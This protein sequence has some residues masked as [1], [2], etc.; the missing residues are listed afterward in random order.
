MEM[1]LP[2]HS[3]DFGYLQDMTTMVIKATR[4][5]PL[6]EKIRVTLNLKRP[7]M[8]IR[9]P[10][11]I[12][13]KGKITERD[14]RF[15]VALD[16]QFSLSE[17][18]EDGV[19]ALVLHV[20]NPPWYSRQLKEAMQMS[21]DPKSF[22]WSA[23][24]TWSRQ[25]DI[26]EEKETYQ[27]ID[28]SPVSVRKLQ[29]S[30]NIAHW[31]TFRLTVKTN[32]ER[33]DDLLKQ[34]LTALADFNIRVTRNPNPP[35]TIVR[36]TAYEATIWNL[37]NASS[38]SSLSEQLS[39]PYLDFG[40]R[41]QLEVC[42][43]H[44]WLNEYALDSSFLQRLAELP[45]QRAKQMLVHID[46][47]EQWVYDPQSIFTDMRYTKPVRAG[48]LPAN[49]AEIYNATV[50][51]TGIL[52][53][54]PSVEIS[55]RI[56]R[57]YQSH[58]D[59]FLRVRFEDDNYRGKTR[60]F[61]ATNGSMKL[62]FERVRR[63]LKEGITIGD[64]HYDFLA[65]GN[66]QLR[67]HGVWFFASSHSPALTADDIRRDMGTFDRENVVA[68]RAARMGQCF[69]T[70]VPVPVLGRK[71]W[72][73]DQIR[74][75]KTANGQY[76]FTD[77]VGKI[78]T[79]AARLVQINL[80]TGG[81]DPPSALQFRLGGCKG[82]LTLDL[83]LKNVSVQIRDSQFKFDCE[84]D[85]LEII[86][87]SEFWQ[88][89]LNRQL[90]LVLSANGVPDSVFLQKQEL[91]I[92]ALDAAL[93]DESAALKALRFTVDPNQITLNIAAMIEAG[94]SHKTDP[95]VTSLIR[96]WRAW[97][98]KYLKE[99]AKIPVQH[100]AFVLG[101]ADE[102]R[103]LKGH[104]DALQPGP[105][106]TPREMENSLP[107]IFIQYSDPQEKGARRVYEG[108]CVVARNPSLHRGD[109]RVVKA[110]DIPE[111][112]H[113]CD[114]VVMPTTGDRDLP[115]MCSG[116][117]LD[118]DDYIVIWDPELIPQHW[119]AE[120]FHYN[121][122]EPL[123][124]DEI[125]TNDIINFFCDYMQNDFLGRIAVAHLA[126]ADFLDD[127]LDSD[128]CLKLVELHSMAVDYPKTGVPAEMSR[129]LERVHWP[130]FME[131]KKAGFYHS[132]KVLGRLYDAVERVNFQPHWQG[133][134]DPRILLHK[135][136]E[137][138]MQT[139]KSLKKSY[140]ES[141]RRIMA[142]HQI[143]SEFEVWSTFVLDH[144]K[145]ARDYKFHEEIGQHAR[146]LKEQFHDA[147]CQEAGGHV[148]E[149]LTPFAITAY[150]VTH[151]EFQEALDM[152]KATKGEHLLVDVEEEEGDDKS[153]EVEMPF[154]SFPWVL[155]DTLQKIA[156]NTVIPETN[157]KVSGLDDQAKRMKTELDAVPSLRGWSTNG[158][159]LPDPYVPIERTAPAQPEMVAAPPPPIPVSL[160]DL[161]PIQSPSKAQSTVGVEKSPSD[162]SVSSNVSL[163]VSPTKSTSSKSDASENQ[164]ST[165]SRQPF[166]L[167]PSLSGA[168]AD[169]LDLDQLLIFTKPTNTPLI[170][171]EKSVSQPFKDPALM[172]SAEIHALTGGAE[173]EDDDFTF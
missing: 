5:D 36:D 47:H 104:F 129:D 39:A 96:L 125:S 83:N 158:E 75:I 127:G 76:T 124:K 40:L 119:N 93:E 111:L 102:T 69:S 15:F 73:R 153:A 113:L 35:F 101:V 46:I 22:R 136:E 123:R 33:P 164:S 144:S 23:D 68:K 42:I 4:T 61:P 169:L 28:S 105:G 86:R 110:V 147:F 55:N 82:V 149:K 97:T 24:D 58:S 128:P 163:A 70:T 130:H 65:W 98:L 13:S 50:T 88:P 56:V 21:H 137:N 106:A 89:Y 118:G 30:I 120:P 9:F 2:A 142:Q 157:T 121:A 51:A 156:R 27:K 138:L 10:V 133:S 19:S 81:T 52:F 134:F 26:V 57:K 38:A 117:D 78:S 6:A 67:E 99:K 16:D 63:T 165:L 159:H 143:R 91:C 79:L 25:T 90:I 95:F 135:P 74:D 34:F 112:H 3:I 114:V 8:E 152:K 139:V 167:K 80:K 53:H 62:I 162:S 54:T 49:C 109:V 1:A 150:H 161:A 151:N 171:A 41:Y 155:Q 170:E 71:S 160:N 100:G 7:E 59:R 43:S 126:A 32:P 154:I 20:K 48:P 132:R 172:T 11:S 29:N 108:I 116:G 45:P 94:F 31:T 145:A 148:F 17:V 84:S 14:Y 64:R 37:L 122:P 60:L 131:K 166:V 146:T 168:G 103:R 115:S 12:K 85:E 87:V 107:Q 77:G 72:R 18:P 92:Q 66:S 173:D 140:D 44:G 141:M